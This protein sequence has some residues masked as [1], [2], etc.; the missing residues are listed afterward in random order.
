MVNLDIVPLNAVIRAEIQ[1]AAALLHSGGTVAFPTET[2]YGLGADA[3]NSLAVRQI[4]KI[5]GRPAFHSLIVHIE[6]ASKLE[7]WARNIPDIA[8]L[9][10]EKFWPGALTL[11]L[12]R[13][14]QVL[15]EITGGQ[16]TVGLRSPDHPVA[17]ALLHEFGGGIAA[18]SANL[19]GRIS[20]T[21]AQHVRDELGAQAGMIL[22]GGACRIGL[23]STILSLASDEPVLLRPGGIAVEAIEN[24]LKKKLNFV[25]TDTAQKIR[26]SGMLDSHYA[27]VTPL[28]LHRANNLW[29]RA[30]HLADLGNKIAVLTFG[31]KIPSYSASIKKIIMPAQ[32]ADYA[33]DLYATLHRLD[34][35][36]YDRLLLESPPATQAWL[37]VNDRLQRA[38]YS[39]QQ[40]IIFERGEE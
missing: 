34:H 32:A 2:V 20:P 19:F 28:E 13:Q 9:L 6:N 14:P 3:S 4:F 29:L 27:P 37:A 31:E 15:N 10:A 35:A 24:V 11:I 12:Q 38:T 33:H 36:G 8:Y 17:Q 21:T 16:D 30:Q 22:D 40:E 18:P 39:T 23:E 26:T 1:A 5:K 25:Q 7:R